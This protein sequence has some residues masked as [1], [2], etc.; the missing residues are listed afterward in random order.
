MVSLHYIT[1]CCSF[2]G[3][4]ATL[5]GCGHMVSSHYITLCCSFAGHW[6]LFLT[7]VTWFLYNTLHYVVVLLAI[8]LL[9]LAVVTWF[10]YITLYY[11]ML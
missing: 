8:A 3:H 1:L 9:Y 2:A 7:V 4:R 5:P 11:L 6:L 10:L